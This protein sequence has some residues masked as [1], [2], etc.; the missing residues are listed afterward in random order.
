MK[1]KSDHAYR[2]QIFSLLKFSLLY[3]MTPRKYAIKKEHLII[4]F[5]FILQYLWR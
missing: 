5:N 3:L 2:W 1:Y 4:T